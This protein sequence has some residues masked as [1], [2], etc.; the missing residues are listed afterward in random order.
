MCSPLD[1]YAQQEAMTFT[2][3]AA[4]SEYILLSRSDAFHAA[5]SQ[6]CS[7]TR[8]ILARSITSI[9]DDISSMFPDRHNSNELDIL[10]ETVLILA[11]R[12]CPNQCFEASISAVSIGIQVQPIPSWQEPSRS[13]REDSVFIV[14][15][16]QARF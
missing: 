9:F 6:T 5:S 15:E 11:S 8:C 13:L 1:L 2:T 10:H 7:Y 3:I 12:P 14:T 4:H 16:I